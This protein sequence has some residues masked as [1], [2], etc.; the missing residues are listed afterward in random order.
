MTL[1]VKPALVTSP[2]GRK[3]I[4]GWEDLFL[5]AYDDATDKI[6]KPNKGYRGTLTIGYG[7]TD[8][9]GPPQVTIGM[10]ITKEEADSILAADLE[11][12]EADVNR[13]VIAPLNQNQFDA[14]VSFH[15]NTGALTRRTC[16]L[17]MAL[18]HRNYKDAAA[19][20]TLYTR[21]GGKVLKG[22]VRRRAAEA[23]LF[24]EGVYV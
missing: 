1:L 13:V 15:F 8:E 19:D 21:A 18:N 3:F 9:A 16:S 5:Q 17:L 24:N 7:H 20:F 2:A 22:L 12:V 14:L 6:V 4:E 10:T 23:K 11:K